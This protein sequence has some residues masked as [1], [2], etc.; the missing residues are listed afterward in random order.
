M[1]CPKCGHMS[2]NELAA[3]QN[4]QLGL[5]ISRAAQAQQLGARGFDQ[6]WAN[7]QAAH[8]Q[9]GQ[10][11]AFGRQGDP[12]PPD[13]LVAARERLGAW[14]VAHPGWVHGVTEN[15]HS[16]ALAPFVVELFTLDW[17]TSDRDV[18]DPEYIE[19]GGPDLAAAI[20][21]ALEKAN[22]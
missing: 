9:H 12:T 16:K 4:Q 17:Y 3:A 19:G 8:Q 5:G 11:L 22:T 6:T 13:P 7:R 15:P 18:P 2:Q 1:S 21:D 20:L 10:D 14:I